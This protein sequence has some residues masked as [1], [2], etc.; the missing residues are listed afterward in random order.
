MKYKNLSGK[1]IDTDKDEVECP[2]C[3]KLYQKGYR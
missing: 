2:W 3:I 1:L